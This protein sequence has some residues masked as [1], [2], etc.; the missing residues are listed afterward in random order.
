MTPEG[1]SI[2]LQRG[3]DWQETWRFLD[4][5]DAAVSLTGITGE[6]LVRPAAGSA[7]VATGT[8]TPTATAGEATL[9]LSA[10]EIAL[11]ADYRVAHW[12]LTLTDPGGE[13]HVARGTVWLS[14]EP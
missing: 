14:D 10:E 4:S 2:E 11:L 13:E 7:V 1:R 9:A 3:S 5:A 6:L 8:F 12:T